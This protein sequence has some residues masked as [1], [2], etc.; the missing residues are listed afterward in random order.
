MKKRCR[1][2]FSMFMAVVVLCMSIV[3]SFATTS[4]GVTTYLTNCS[5]T[6]MSFGVAE[7]EASFYVS[8][9]GREATFVQAKLTVQI[10]K[11]FLGL[12]W[13]D[14]ADEWVGY[15]TE[16]VGQIYDDIPIDGTGT[17]RAIFK[18]EVFGSTGV[19]DVIEDTLQYKY[20]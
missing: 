9:M 15:S 11:K 10:Q 1:V 2:V 8:Y 5:T 17:Y 6:S 14:A 20:T 16:V 7:G 3:P 13:R 4:D 19:T 18:L 12:F